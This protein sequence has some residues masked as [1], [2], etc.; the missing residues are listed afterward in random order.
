ML[1]SCRVKK[2][3]VYTHDMELGQIAFKVKDSGDD[4]SMQADT[5]IS[6]ASAAGW[7]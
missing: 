2:E 6:A 3:S 5:P 4:G 7:Y 1:Y